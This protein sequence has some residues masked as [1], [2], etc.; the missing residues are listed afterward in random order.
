MQQLQITSSHNSEDIL[1]NNQS[2]VKMT[3]WGIAVMLP[4]FFLCLEAQGQRVKA[5]L[6]YKG[7]RLQPVPGG[8]D[9]RRHCQATG[10]VLPSIS[11]LL[12]HCMLQPQASWITCFPMDL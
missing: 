10:S 3:L 8:L 4:T 5:V 9:S 12:L 2:K 6:C 7:H 11:R 1:E